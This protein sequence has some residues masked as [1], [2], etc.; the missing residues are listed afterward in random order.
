MCYNISVKATIPENLLPAF[1]RYYELLTEW[2]A[3][4]NLTSVTER[5]GVY[6]K[7]FA[8]SLS[9]AD[10]FPKNAEVC[11]VGSGAGFPG[12]PLKLARPD[13]NVT[14][15][16]SLNKRVNFLNAV[17]AA[18]N[19]KGI[20]AEHIRA[21]DA[22]AKYRESFDCAAARAVA[23]LN[24][25]CEYALPLVKIGGRLIAYKSAD[26]LDEIAGAERAV[27]KLGGRLLPVEPFIIESGDGETLSRALIVIEKVSK[28]PKEYPRGGNKATTDPL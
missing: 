25:L 11:D 27:K 16:D 4:I 26:C 21:E 20:R 6:L 14:L 2:N 19:L 28:T 24:T 8:D 23:A 15:I 7:H 13:L 10:L 17:I 18:L 1:E 9:G 12:I 5:D 22:A 3:K